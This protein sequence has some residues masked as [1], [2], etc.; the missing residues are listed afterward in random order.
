MQEADDHARAK[1]KR[2]SEGERARGRN[3]GRRE[4]GRV[5]GDRGE[6]GRDAVREGM[7]CLTFTG[8]LVMCS[9]NSLY[10][11]TVPP[12]LMALCSS[13]DISGLLPWYSPAGGQAARQ[14]R[15]HAGRQ[16]YTAGRHTRQAHKA[17]RQADTHGKQGKTQG[18]IR[19]G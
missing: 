15:R 5:G 2:F 4:E 16:A 18:R 10:C 13:L 19:Q 9:W 17:G 1:W 14:A 8:L 3:G 7:K 12:A 11:S 6:V